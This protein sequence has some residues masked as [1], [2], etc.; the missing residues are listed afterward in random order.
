MEKALEKGYKIDK[1]YEVWHFE[2]SSTELFKEYIRKFLKIKLETSKFTCSEEDYR[3]KGSKFG[4]QLGELKENP[5]MRF[6]SKICLN[7]L[8]GKFGQHPKFR[9][10]EYIDTEKDFYRVILD[11]E[12]ENIALFFL[13]NEMVYTSYE[14]KDEFIKTNYNGNIYIACFTTSWARLRLYNMLEKLDK[15]VCYSDTD[16]IVYIEDEQTKKIIDKY[17]GDSLGEWTNEL[18]NQ[19]IVYWCSAQSKDYG[20][21]LDNSKNV[22]KVKGFKRTGESEEKMTIEQRINLIKGAIYNIDINY[23][24]FN[25][26]Y[27]E[28]ATKHMVKQ[29]AFKFNKRI[30]KQISDDEIDTFPYGY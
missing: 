7:S 20:Y 25:I 13:T 1:I 16:S 26:K 4:I 23:E 29:W 21:I 9:H 18:D 27:C 2:N 3:Q 12:I 24:H 8:Y 10:S 11:E 19:H 14:K 17:I 28:I 6:I 22:G 5:G 15:N 30:I